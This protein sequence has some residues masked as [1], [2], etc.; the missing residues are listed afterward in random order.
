MK[1]LRPKPKEEYPLTIPHIIDSI[2]QKIKFS[3]KDLKVTGILL[4]PYYRGKK[5][6]CFTN[7]NLRKATNDVKKRCLYH[8][9]EKIYFR[10]QQLITKRKNIYLRCRHCYFSL[11]RAEYFT[12][13][14]TIDKL[15]K[16]TQYFINQALLHTNEQFKINIKTC[17]L[18]IQR[19]K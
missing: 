18:K 6:G 14:I 5:M 13:E 4:T 11:M 9:P 3:N 10:G 16:D 17:S 7:I 15:L 2:R 19:G 8:G 12:I 1:Y